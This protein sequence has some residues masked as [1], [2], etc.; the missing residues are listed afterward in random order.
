[1]LDRMKAAY[2]R[3]MDNPPFPSSLPVLANNPISSLSAND[4]ATFATSQMFAAPPLIRPRKAVIR[5]N[6]HLISV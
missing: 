1:M 6:T 2:G 3:Q 4:T 5:L